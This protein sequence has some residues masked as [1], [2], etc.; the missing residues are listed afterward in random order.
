[1]SLQEINHKIYFI[2]GHRIMLD[3]DHI[4]VYALKKYFRENLGWNALN[5][6]CMRHAMWLLL[7]NSGPG[8]RCY[9]T[10]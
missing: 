2:R 8:L 3:V 7:S 6:G 9:D 4:W 1:M 10:G 5:Q